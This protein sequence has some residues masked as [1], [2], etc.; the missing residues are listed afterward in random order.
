[1]IKQGVGIW[2]LMCFPVLRGDVGNVG[3]H[4]LSSLVERERS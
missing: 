1:M 2:K 4:T 3:K